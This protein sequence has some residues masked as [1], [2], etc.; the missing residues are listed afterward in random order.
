MSTER[1]LPSRNPARLP[2][3][4]LPDRPPRERRQERE[5][6]QRANDASGQRIAQIPMRGQG[7]RQQHQPARRNAVFSVERP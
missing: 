2:R 3:L 5:Q 1:G 4:H 6:A 7:D